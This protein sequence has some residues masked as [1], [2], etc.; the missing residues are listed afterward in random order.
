MHGDFS[1]SLFATF[2]SAGYFRP[3][4]TRWCTDKGC[5][6]CSRRCKD[7]ISYSP[8]CLPKKIK[9]LGHRFARINNR[10]LDDSWVQLLGKKQSLVPYGTVAM[11]APATWLCNSLQRPPGSLALAPATI[12]TPTIYLILEERQHSSFSRSCRHCTNTGRY[13]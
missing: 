2:A 5:T 3:A 12:N 7:R 8:A 10:V 1:W 9:V 6:L 11:T 4:S 13:N